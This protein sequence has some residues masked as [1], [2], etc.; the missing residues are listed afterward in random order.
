[1]GCRVATRA[2]PQH[3]P[4]SVLMKFQCHSIKK[5]EQRDTIISRVHAPTTFNGC[6]VYEQ[7]PS[8]IVGCRV[9]MR[10]GWTHR[11]MDRQ[12]GGRTDGTGHNNTLW[13][14]WAEGKNANSK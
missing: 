3:H 1:M 11:Q 13:P 8:N 5:N 6:K 4:V 2:G 9:V 7:N 12:M 10:A 14:E